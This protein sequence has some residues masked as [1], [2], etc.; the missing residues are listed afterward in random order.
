MLEFDFSPL[1][2]EVDSWVLLLELVSD[3]VGVVTGVSVW[4]V[5]VDLLLSFVSAVFVSAVCW[6]ELWVVSLTSVVVC[7]FADV[8]SAWTSWPLLKKNVV[9]STTAA[10]PITYEN[11]ISLY[12]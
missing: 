6:S 12:H 8:S 3:E 10:K 5:S 9:P 2:V 7:W 1:L 4:V 11:L